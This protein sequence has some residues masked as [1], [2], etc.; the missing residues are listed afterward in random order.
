MDPVEIDD[1]AIYKCVVKNPVGQDQC[2]A[3]ILVEGTAAFLAHNWQL[4][5]SEDSF[6][7]P[8]DIRLLKKIAP[9]PRNFL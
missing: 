4:R 7:T 8:P 6:A 1:E 3:E 9:R 5:D 2:E